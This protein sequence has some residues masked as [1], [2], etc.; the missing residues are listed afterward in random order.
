MCVYVGLK[1]EVYDK[2]RETKSVRMSKKKSM[3]V[4]RKERERERERK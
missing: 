2:R 1:G 3:Y 4:T